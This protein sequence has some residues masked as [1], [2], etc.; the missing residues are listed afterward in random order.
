MTAN[1]K[2]YDGFTDEERAAMKEHATELKATKRRGAKADTE[3]EVLAK[4]AEMEDADRVLAERVHALVKEHAPALTA[5]LWYGMPA[6]ARDG[7][8]VCFFQSAQKF[9]SRYATL[10][11]S[12]QAALDEDTLWPTAYALTALDPATEKRIAALIEQAAG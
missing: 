12:D 10:G 8:V 11:F 5:K 6:Y 9:K 1:S 7:K 4:I 3:P 2:S